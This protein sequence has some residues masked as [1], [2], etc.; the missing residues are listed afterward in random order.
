MQEG[1]TADKYKAKIAEFFKEYINTH[2]SNRRVIVEEVTCLS[3]SFI[4]ANSSARV[5]LKIF[6][7]DNIDPAD[8]AEIKSMFENS[9][10]IID[11]K[12]KR[13]DTSNNDTNIT[14]AEAAIIDKL[15]FYTAE[16][17]EYT[18]LMFVV[19]DL[20]LTEFFYIGKYNTIQ[21]NR[22]D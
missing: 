17:D 10:L 11:Q 7:D 1:I 6:F 14:S 2:T 22:K 21:L 5:I 9:I 3:F 4:P 20:K 18:D 12:N 19:F 16:D 8:I 13:N 15:I